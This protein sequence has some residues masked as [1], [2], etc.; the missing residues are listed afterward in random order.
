MPRYYSINNLQTDYY[1]FSDGTEK[2]GD[3]VRT[4]P[5]KERVFDTTVRAPQAV[6]NV[7]LPWL[8]VLV[9][10]V[11]TIDPPVG[12]KTRCQITGHAGLYVSVA[13]VGPLRSSPFFFVG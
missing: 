8:T 1:V 10:Q 12:I 2:S 5:A 7:F 9:R 11:I 13:K 4:V 6:I 3:I